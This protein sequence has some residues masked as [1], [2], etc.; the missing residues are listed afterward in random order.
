[1]STNNNDQQYVPMLISKDSHSLETK[2]MFVSPPTTSSAIV[3]VTNNIMKPR[4]RDN[5]SNRIVYLLSIIGFVVDLGNVWRFP[6]T[7]YRNGGGAFLVPYFTFLFLVGLPCMYLELAIGQYHRLGYITIWN[8]ICPPLKGIGYSMLIINLYVLSYYNTIIAWSVHYCIASFRFIVPW[9]FCDNEWNTPLCYSLHNKGALQVAHNAS[10]SSTDEYY[11]RRMLKSH[12]SPSINQLGSL[13]WELVGCSMIVFFLIYASIFKGVK[14]AGKAIWFTAL[15]PYGVLIILLLR[16]LTLDGILEGL[17]YYV[18]PSFTRLSEYSVWQAAAVQIFFSLGPGFGVLLSYASFSNTH[19]NVSSTALIASFVN[20]CTSLLYGTVVF[21]GLGYLSH[22]LHSDV[23]QFT[24]SN[25]GLVFVVYPEI[26]TS[27]RGAPFFSILFF[28]ML[29]TLGL[30][31][32]FA[33]AESIYT[34]IS[35]EFPILARRPRLSRACVVLVPFLASIPT[36]THGGKYIVHFMD[37]FGTSPSI[38]FVVL[39]ELIAT[40]WLYGIDRFSSDVE[41]MTGHKPSIYWRITCRYVAPLIL[42]ILYVCSFI[43]FD[44]Q[45]FSSFGE[46]NTA[47]RVSIAGWTISAIS[48]LPI[49][50][51]ACW[52]LLF[53]RQAYLAEQKTK[54]ATVLPETMPTKGLNEQEAFI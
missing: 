5:W 13:Q 19:D 27:I 11:E 42:L 12:L 48:T 53:R 52:W 26:L 25:M 39:C 22:R 33:G 36:L 28:I 10:C 35:D 34:A 23:R 8:K 17:K 14:T 49:P 2:N 16:S 38:M 18:A 29:L 50:I 4:E 46:G 44:S 37:F 51:Y 6:T 21:A 43:Q 20:C 54:T 7:C 41:T 31:S 3:Q 32:V 40:V 30:D 45:E 9:T 15:V 24:E 47:L 1:M